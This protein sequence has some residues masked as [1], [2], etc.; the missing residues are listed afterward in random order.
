MGLLI[1]TFILVG[2]MYLAWRDLYGPHNWRDDD[3]DDRGS[4]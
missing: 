1:F 3:E 4:D 2:V